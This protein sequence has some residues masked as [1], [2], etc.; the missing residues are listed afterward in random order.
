M[1]YS[2]FSTK[3]VFTIGDF[4]SSKMFAAITDTR[5]TLINI[6]HME[7]FRNQIC[8]NAVKIHPGPATM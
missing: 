7:L 3:I 5:E 6:S 8:R 4:S 1:T 2:A